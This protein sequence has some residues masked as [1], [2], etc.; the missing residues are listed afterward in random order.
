M[1]PPTQ[2]PL[3]RPRTSP[4]IARSTPATDLHASGKVQHAVT[5][6]ELQTNQTNSVVQKRHVDASQEPLF[7]LLMVPC[8]AITY[9]DM[10][11]AILKRNVSVMYSLLQKH[12]MLP[13]NHLATYD[14][15]L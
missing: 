5:L 7:A 12:A 6:R 4:S 13:A 3:Q 14:G 10:R 2:Q 11:N 9:E 1:W 8:S 15:C